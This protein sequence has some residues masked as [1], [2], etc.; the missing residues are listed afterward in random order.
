MLTIQCVK[1]NWK[2]AL[3]W[4]GPVL[5]KLDNDTLS[6]ISDTKQ[7]IPINRSAASINGLVRA[8]SSAQQIELS[9]LLLGRYDMPGVPCL[10]SA[11]IPNNHKIP[12]NG[13]SPSIPVQTLTN[14]DNAEKDDQSAWRLSA[15]WSLKSSD[16]LKLKVQLIL[17]NAFFVRQLC[18]LQEFFLLWSWIVFAPLKQNAIRV[19][20]Y[21]SKASK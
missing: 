11:W 1:L 20:F 4:Q 21:H 16:E 9:P 15:D 19:L 8:Q 13:S 14:V 6:L 10:Q 7:S 18:R 17:I 12:K 5:D 3:V 2:S